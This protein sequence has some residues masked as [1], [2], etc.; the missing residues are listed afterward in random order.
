MGPRLQINW[1][2]IRSHIRKKTIYTYLPRHPP[3][4]APFHG[5]ASLAGLSGGHV[6][7]G[8]RGRPTPLR[9]PAASR[10]GGGRT[11]GQ[12]GPPP[13]PPLHPVASSTSPRRGSSPE[14]QPRAC[15]P[16]VTSAWPDHSAAWPHS[17]A[18]QIL[19]MFPGQTLWVTLCTRGQRRA[20]VWGRKAGRGDR[21]GPPSRPHTMGGLAGSATPHSPGVPMARSARW[22]WPVS[23]TR[24]PKSQVLCSLSPPPKLNSGDSRWFC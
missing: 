20:G 10:V 2:I 4:F 19:R 3:T 7:A 5:D 16:G 6:T 14:V 9:T 8:G 11:R 23:R 17:R 12:R 13:T 22:P 1:K 18:G 21:A 15:D 24:R